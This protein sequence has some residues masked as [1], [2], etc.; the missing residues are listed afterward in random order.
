MTQERP[1]LGR[2]VVLIPIAKI[3]FVFVSFLI[4]FG[5][6]N[7]LQPDEVG[8]YGVVNR[9]VSLINMVMISGT[10]QAVSK[11]VSEDPTRTTAM[12]RWAL[13]A[14]ALFALTVSA[15]YF[16]LAAPIANLLNDPSLILYIRISSAIPVLYAFYAVHVGVFNGTKDFL[17]QASFDMGYAALRATGILGAAALGFG[18]GGIFVAFAS[19]A[20]VILVIATFADRGAPRGI[21]RQQ[22][23]LDV[24]TKQVV[25][26]AL[27]VMVLVLVQQWML[28]FDLF[29]VKALVPADQSSL[30][31]GAYFSMLNLA[32]VPYMLVLSINFIVFPLISK[33]T[34]DADA[35]TTRVYLRQS[36]RIAL[37]TALAMEIVVFGSPEAALGMGYPTKPEYLAYADALQV[38]ALAY[39]CLCVF[40]VMIALLNGAGRPLVSLAG[41]TATL[42]LQGILC[43]VLV[44]SH[45]L[46]GAALAT[47][48]AFALGTA[49]LAIYLLRRY[50]AWIEPATLVRSGIAAAIGVVVSRTLEWT[51]VMF[52][53]EAIVT[54]LAFVVVLV[55][56]REIDRKDVDRLM[57]LVRPA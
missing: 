52:L 30:L 13:R 7:L 22:T 38:L 53:A 18:V 17:K 32:L 51:G 40:A 48:I 54:A 35:E 42:V 56:L 49:I 8:D 15:L 5:L 10:I 36:L 29:W 21:A 14:Q 16:A 47:A 19:A 31:A 9:L 39:V 3:W 25:T 11:F 43:S 28:S 24:T 57:S 33:A 4:N 20:A 41:G 1:D 37:L 55:V 34:F 23:E 12:R 44:R 26:F 2:G 50:G 46:V 6:P 27:P 45:G